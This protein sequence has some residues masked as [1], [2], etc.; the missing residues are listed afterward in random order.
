MLFQE[1]ISWSFKSDNSLLVRFPKTKS[2][3][4]LL[5]RIEPNGYRG[6]LSL[7]STFF[8]IK[9][10][11]EDS[12]ALRIL[13]R[14]QCNDAE[15]TALDL[16]FRKFRRVLHKMWPDLSFQGK[17]WVN[18]VFYYLGRAIIAPGYWTT[19]TSFL[20]A[21]QD[22]T[23]WEVSI[24][25]FSTDG[26]LRYGALIKPASENKCPQP[27][28]ARQVIITERGFWGIRQRGTLEPPYLQGQ[29]KFSGFVR[30]LEDVELNPP[31]DN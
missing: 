21:Y 5:F 13:T 16:K 29:S 31:N 7:R 24:R 10:R 1:D 8:K 28:T 23:L 6:S 12:E 15:G 2:S 25:S 20:Q 3:P 11:F 26:L 14:I 18:P 17:L 9:L 19:W 30:A 22:K 4:S 27:V